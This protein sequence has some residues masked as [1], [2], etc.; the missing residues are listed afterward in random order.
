MSLCR[1]ESTQ[2]PGAVGA[3]VPK[4]SH[5]AGSGLGQVVTPAWCKEMAPDEHMA[6]QEGQH[7]DRQAGQVDHEKLGELGG[8]RPPAALRKG[9]ETVPDEGVTDGCRERAG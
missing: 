1:S 6:S 9:P 7:I 5:A 2:C 4:Q 8:Q 3:E